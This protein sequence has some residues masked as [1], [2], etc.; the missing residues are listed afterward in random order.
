[1][2]KTLIV[3]LYGAPGTGKSTL[4]AETFAALKWD[5]ID[6]EMVPEFAKE[7][8]WE[9]RHHTMTDQLYLLGKQHHRIFRVNGKVEVVITDSP[10]LLN[11]VYN[12]L[13]NTNDNPKQ[14]IFNDALEKVVIAADG[15]YWTLNIFLNRTKDYNPNGRN[16]TEEESNELS[17]IIRNLLIENNIKF[18]DL[19]ADRDTAIEI[20]KLI[21]DELKNTEC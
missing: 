4:M 6:S 12:R 18:K 1:M 17:V 5:K 9:K 15:L 7:L 3:N 20:A 21:E 10:I 13:Y 8:V 16:Q 14:T 2:K 19:D 11:T